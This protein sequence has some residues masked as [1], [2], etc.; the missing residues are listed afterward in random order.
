MQD[1]LEVDFPVNII[2]GKKDELIPY[3]TSV[4]FISKLKSPR[5]E[6]VLKENGDHFMRDEGTKND[7]LEMFK[8]YTGHVSY[9]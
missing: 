8:K 6:L 5:V 2:H 3:M 4:N 1:N 9:L 7:I